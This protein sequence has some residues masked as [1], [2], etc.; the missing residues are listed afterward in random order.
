MH[1]FAWI[2]I[3]I[4]MGQNNSKTPNTIEEGLIVIL[5]LIIL[6]FQEMIGY[7]FSTTKDV[8]VTKYFIVLKKNSITILENIGLFSYIR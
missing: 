2:G 8:Y 7:V 5:S 6:Y 1:T 4:E 3:H